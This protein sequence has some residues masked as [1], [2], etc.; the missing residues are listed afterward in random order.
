[1]RSACTQHVRSLEHIELLSAQWLQRSQPFEAAILP[2]NLFSNVS[3]DP[4]DWDVRQADG[5]I[6]SSAGL[7]HHRHNQWATQFIQRFD[8]RSKVTKVVTPRDGDRTHGV[9]SP[10][11]ADED[12]AML[13]SQ[14]TQESTG[15]NGIRSFGLK[16]GLQGARRTR[17]HDDLFANQP[18]HQRNEQPPA[19]SKEHPPPGAGPPADH[20]VTWI[21]RPSLAT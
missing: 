12:D 17:Q 11:V 3:L 16:S 8:E 15:L 20:A 21:K 7:A 10:R 1:M 14:P 5:Q 13:Q 19:K 4:E 6:T 9:G 2:D 18:H